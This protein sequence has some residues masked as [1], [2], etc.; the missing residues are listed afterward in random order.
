MADCKYKINIKDIQDRYKFKVFM[1]S[2]ADIPKAITDDISSIKSNN[3]ELKRSIEE[4]KSETNQII[5]ENIKKKSQNQNMYNALRTI[6]TNNIKDK[7]IEK[8]NLYPDIGEESPKWLNL[9][10]WPID[11][12]QKLEDRYVVR[13]GTPKY[14]G[15]HV[16]I[17]YQQI[18]QYKFS[19]YIKTSVDNEPVM[20]Y[21]AGRTANNKQVTGR[22]RGTTE[23][24][25]IELIFYK[26][27]VSVPDLI[28][29]EKIETSD[30]I[31]YI[32]KFELTPYG[33]IEKVENEPKEIILNSLNLINNTKITK[34]TTQ[35]V[36]SVI[37]GEITSNELSGWSGMNIL[38]TNS[39]MLKKDKI[40]R[41]SFDI[42]GINNVDDF[43]KALL[44]QKANPTV[45]IETT[46]NK[47]VTNYNL[48]TE[49]QRY[50]YYITPKADVE[51]N[52]IWVQH[53]GNKQTSNQFVIRNI[54]LSES[55]SDWDENYFKKSFIINHF[56][57][58]DDK[59]VELID[60]MIN[61]DLENKRYLLSSD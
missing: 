5:E 18:G 53:N 9:S 1:R 11:R 61:L 54:M 45:G 37:D 27:D 17:T 3:E 22:Y 60:E 23:W 16:P 34:E 38:L 59:F 21:G 41:L 7:V 20:I 51:T 31:L 43:N 13:K 10:F 12:T 49:Y 25:K 44:V 14:Y 33:E 30:T 40:Y 36:F 42:K 56:D 4:L 47:L 8:I 26:T 28:R 57:N 46:L 29:I 19:A 55:S 24:Q 58:T 52:K 39:I 2:G 6:Y 50:I 48:T 35:N 32:S 15:I